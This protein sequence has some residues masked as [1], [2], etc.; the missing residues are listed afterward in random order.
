MVVANNIDYKR[1]VSAIDFYSSK[2]F[3]Y[4]DLDWT[5]PSD[6]SEITKPVECKDTYIGNKVL[7]GSAEQTFMT[8][9]MSGELEPGR[10]CGLTPC[11]RDDSVDEFHNKYF[12]KLELIDTKDVDEASLM[13]IIKICEEYFSKYMYVEVIPVINHYNHKVIDTHTYDIQDIRCGIEIGS[14][15]IRQFDNYKWIFSTGLAEPRFSKVLA[16]QNK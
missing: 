11:F 1:L 16:L 8:M 4:I 14:Y 10:Y 5:I 9:L 13:D 12:M 15:G 2:G 6:I 7:V 3:K